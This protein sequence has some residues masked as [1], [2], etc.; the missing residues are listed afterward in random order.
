MH[1]YNILWCCFAH[2]S[3][4]DGDVGDDDGVGE[5]IDSEVD[6]NHRLWR[7]DGD[8]CDVMRNDSSDDG[9]VDNGDNSD[10]NGDD[11]NC[12]GCNVDN[13]QGRPGG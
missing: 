2:N 8:D 10:G 4:G 5:D 11:S 13:S 12:L 1:N 9:G 6:D 3:N 7:R